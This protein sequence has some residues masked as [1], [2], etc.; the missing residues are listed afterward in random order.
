MGMSP[1]LPPVAA[2]RL[3]ADLNDY[4]SLSKKEREAALADYMAATEERQMMLDALE[5]ATNSAVADRA[6]AAQELDES[7]AFAKTTTDTA[8]DKARGIV[9][10]AASQAESVNKTVAETVAMAKA[11]SET[12][13]MRLKKRENAVEKREDACE[14]REANAFKEREEDVTEREQA[15]EEGEKNLKRLTAAGQTAKETYEEM[16]RE[17]NALQR[18]VPK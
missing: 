9:A 11:N 18:R 16:I 6:A 14:L 2:F 10:A 7:V 13:G 5:E 8:H 4:L 1:K 15:V 12:G 17:I 3:L